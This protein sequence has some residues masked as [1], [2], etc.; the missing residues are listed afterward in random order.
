MRLKYRAYNLTGNGARLEVAAFVVIALL[1]SF[2]FY[3]YYF[4]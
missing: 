3:L 1:M 2:L 4:A